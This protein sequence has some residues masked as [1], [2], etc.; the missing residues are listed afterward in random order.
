MGA[1]GTLI[2]WLAAAT[3][4]GS[5]LTGA[6]LCL[7]FA[8][9]PVMSAR[10]R[11]ALWLP[12]IFVL[13]APVLPKSK[14][15]VEGWFAKPTLSAEACCPTVRSASGPAAELPGL[16]DDSAASRIGW[17]IVAGCWLAGA[18]WF[19]AVVTSIHVRAMR[20]AYRETDM[21]SESIH[22]LLASVAASLGIKRLPQ[23]LVSRRIENPAVTGCFNP[24]LLLP[25]TF[26]DT[27]S[28]EEAALVIKHELLHI[29][30]GDL[31]MTWLLFVLQA[32]HWFNPMA[33]LA[34]GRMRADCERARDEDVLEH[35]GSGCRSAYGSA[36][37]KVAESA[38]RLAAEPGILGVTGALT[39]L[40]SRIEAVASY[41]APR[42]TW[43]ALWI[44]VLAVMGVV[45][46]TRLPDPAAAAGA[47]R[48]VG[49]ESEMVP[50]QN[51][52]LRDFTVKELTVAETIQRLRSAALAADRDGH[53]LRISLTPEGNR[54]AKDKR[55]SLALHNTS[56]WQALVAVA[57]Q[58]NLGLDGNA[59][60]VCMNWPFTGRTWLV[61]EE[62]LTPLG[63]APT[64]DPQRWFEKKGI[65]FPPGSFAHIAPAHVDGTS[66]QW[67]SVSVR[68]S[69]ENLQR[70][71]SLIGAKEH[72][73]SEA[74]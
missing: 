55:I 72:P 11:L 28:P 21:A 5:L 10:W 73:L 22:Q 60:M 34:F 57:S 61:E 53:G 64:D 49:L 71:G 20:R 43:S 4:R 8:L 33:W 69:Q 13:M 2:S 35:G 3:I 39:A 17:T 56:V 40:K 31:W 14:W 6:V 47:S 63:F 27:L 29:R 41:R 67:L 12:V 66:H 1:L 36:L 23:L 54:I 44:A 65:S 42:R 45:G 68:N 50:A 48:S 7:Q 9:R 70:I 24:V 51:M 46:A 74:P 19:L 52:I 18:V 59:Q 15:S 62:A 32:V 16:S 25:S 58:A 26:P 37:I 30:R 38:G